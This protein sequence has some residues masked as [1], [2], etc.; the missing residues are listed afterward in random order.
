MTSS[1]SSPAFDTPEHSLAQYIH[2]RL[3][4]FGFADLALRIDSESGSSSCETGSRK[5]H[6]SGSSTGVKFRLGAEDCEGGALH[7]AC[8]DTHKDSLAFG[9]NCG[10]EDTSLDS[11]SLQQHGSLAM[12]ELPESGRGS[13]ALSVL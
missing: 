13:R 9:Q 2:L 11:L 5:R 4:E 12:M 3:P 1:R 6:A 8:A 10:F 7:S